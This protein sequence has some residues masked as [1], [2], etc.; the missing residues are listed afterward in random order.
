MNF[1]LLCRFS[2]GLAGLPDRLGLGFDDR[3]ADWSEE[4]EPEATD[5]DRGDDLENLD[6]CRRAFGEAACDRTCLVD[7]PRYGEDLREGEVRFS[8]AVDLEEVDDLDDE[9]ACCLVVFHGSN[10]PNSVATLHR[11]RI[12]STALVESYFHR[13]KCEQSAK[14]GRQMLY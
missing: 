4:P 11:P 14:Y 3:P 7:R 9:G 10:I 5:V 2:G 1:A 12:K 6:V 13:K 8:A